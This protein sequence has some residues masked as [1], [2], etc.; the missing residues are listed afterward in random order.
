MGQAVSVPEPVWVEVWGER[1]GE[2][3]PP[4]PSVLRVLVAGQ[5]AGGI[6]RS[7]FAWVA[8]V[9]GLRRS[10]PTTHDTAEEGVRAILRSSWA[11]RLGARAASR[12]HWSER[13]KRL[14]AKPRRPAAAPPANVS[15]GERTPHRD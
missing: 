6:E 11:R 7:E 14:A 1:P 12:V 13:A 8:Q 15:S 2:R 5:H 10:E 3:K 4:G 9:H